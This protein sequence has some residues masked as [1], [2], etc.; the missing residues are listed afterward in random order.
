MKEHIQ[1]RK[2]IYQELLTLLDNLKRESILVWGL[3]FILMLLTFTSPFFYKVF[4]DTV[5]I[6]RNHNGLIIVI[7][8]I[9]ITF[10][11][12]VIVGKYNVIFT[13]KLKNE[14]VYGIQNKILK[15]YLTEE[16]YINKSLG[17]L[18]QIIESDVDVISDFVE[19][20]IIQYTIQI[21]S[22]VLLTVFLFCIN[23]HLALLCIILL[24]AT[25]VIDYF[26]AR[27]ENVINTKVHYLEYSRHDFVHQC[28][29]NFKEIKT[30]NLEKKAR[31]QYILWLHRWAK[32]NL[33]YLNNVVLKDYIMPKVKEL[34]LG[35][36]LIYILGGVIVMKG[37]LTIGSL[38]IFAQYYYKTVMSIE[39]L[40]ATE[41]S[42]E[43]NKVYYDK[44]IEAVK[45]KSVENLL[46]SRK[47]ILQEIQKVELE[48]AEFHYKNDAEFHLRHIDFS[49]KSGERVAFV[50]E[51]GGGKST[52]IEMLLGRY[53]LDK[54]CLKINGMNEMI[55]DKRSYYQNIGVIRQDCELLNISIRDNLLMG[56]PEAEEAEI[57][58]A[59]KLS[60]SYEFVFTLEYR[61]DTVVGEKGIKLSGGQRQR[62]LLARVFLRNPQ[63]FIFDEASSSLDNIAEEAI[64]RSI[65]ELAVDKLVIIITHKMSVVKICNKVYVMKDGRVEKGDFNEKL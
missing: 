12:Q 57:I 10:F 3:Q 56:K 44:V 34:I 20:Q 58:R 15:N 54:G 43:R 42:I 62:L 17:E 9:L 24:F 28:L 26:L 61:L 33:I 7:S 25:Y 19:K 18:K 52:M 59:L 38:L 39:E 46:S 21:C 13:N 2:Y 40:S 63:L 14:S 22:T 1:Y 27:K 55:I 5:I 37:Q 50:G 48:D 49:V 23:A 29:V 60:G 65:G 16:K 32:F 31:Q 45:Y 51:S 35:R 4:V 11:L 64:L 53:K 41:F 8:G 36:V 30:L 47:E 6:E